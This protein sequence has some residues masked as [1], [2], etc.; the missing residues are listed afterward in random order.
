[1][2]IVLESL[3]QEIQELKLFSHNNQFLHCV[4]LMKKYAK[5][6]LLM[7]IPLLNL[8]EVQISF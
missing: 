1:M 5:L 3:M 6:K 7:L 4:F 8:L 2:F